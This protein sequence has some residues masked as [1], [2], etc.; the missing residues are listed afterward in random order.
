MNLRH[1]PAL[2]SALLFLSVPAL[3]ADAPKEGAAQDA[4]AKKKGHAKDKKKSADRSEKPEEKDAPKKKSA[5][6]PKSKHASL[7]KHHDKDRARS[8][9][10]SKPCF[11][12]A[13][14]ILR[15]T[16][17]KEHV[18]LTR[19]DG[20]ANEKAV[21]EMSMLARPL[22]VAKNA[23][24]KE[25]D[26][27]PEG[28][29]PV[30]G[31]LMIRLQHIADHFKGK[32]VTIVSGYRP[33]SVGSYHHD[34]KALDIHLEGVKNEE[35]VTFCRG[36]KDTGCGYY[37]NSSFVHVDVRPK[38]TGHVYWI[39][40]SGPGEKPRYVSSWPPPKD[41][42]SETVK[43]DPKAPTDE[44]T[45]PDSGPSKAGHGI[46]ATDR[47][48]ESDKGDVEEKADA[49]EPNANPKKLSR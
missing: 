47:D 19:C 46:G 22:S 41:A 42:D 20:E 9:S 10:T 5:H 17:E 7:E 11:H 2:V 38:G 18:T 30:D 3:A 8:G 44:H 36:L 40:A 12:D 34:A 48:D 25:K 32:P 4:K 49:K 1:G 21:R 43:A 29:K 39:D 35:L 31:G 28:V 23:P 33:G 15:G 37:P 26:K 45:N 13:V 27:L 14:E 6:R 16:G 24:S